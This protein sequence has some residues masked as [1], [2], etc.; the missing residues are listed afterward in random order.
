MVHTA[1]ET[2]VERILGRDES[3]SVSRLFDVLADE[4]RRTVVAVLLEQTAPITVETLARRVAAR[5]ADASPAN[6]PTA[7]VDEVHVSLHHVHLPK[8]AQAGLL[9]YDAGDGV[10]RD[11]ALQKDD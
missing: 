10:V 9:T 7:D 4:R 5:D 2:A 6:V 3:A 11:V 8:M 1:A